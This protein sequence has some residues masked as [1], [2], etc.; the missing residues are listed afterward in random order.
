VRRFISWAPFVA[1]AIAAAVGGYFPGRMVERLGPIDS[2]ATPARALLLEAGIAVLAAI[3]GVV[4]RYSA[5]WDVAAITSGVI[6]IALCIGT[7]SAFDTIAGSRDC[8]GT[9][10]CDT[11]IVPVLLP[12]VVAAGVG[13][14]AAA[15]A[16]EGLLRRRL[17]S[18]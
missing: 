17:R 4:S 14:A 18:A 9:Q 11:L 2:A 6:T 3:L 7:Y 15:F 16:T 5:S 13:A 12:L 8:P 10:D 1:I